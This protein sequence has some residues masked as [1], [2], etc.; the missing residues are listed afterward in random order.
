MKESLKGNQCEMIWRVH[1]PKSLPEPW[2]LTAKEN[3]LCIGRTGLL[4]WRP[5]CCRMEEA[6]MEMQDINKVPHI[7][8]M[9]LHR[10][11]HPSLI[12]LMQDITMCPA[13]PHRELCM[14]KMDLPLVHLRVV[15][16]KIL[17]CVQLNILSVWVA[18]AYLVNLSFS[19]P[20]GLINSS[21]ILNGPLQC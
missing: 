14:T 16:R 7:A 15:S 2:S 1:R 10:L 17:L 13:S 8:I 9:T 21:E 5:M 20:W 3:R 12:H 19:N 4:K 11:V 6:Q 18:L